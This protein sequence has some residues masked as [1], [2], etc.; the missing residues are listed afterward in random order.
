MLNFECRHLESVRAA[1][2]FRGIQNLKL[3]TQ[4]FPPFLPKKWDIPNP[5]FPLH[6]RR[7][8]NLIAMRK[9]LLPFLILCSFVSYAQRPD[10]Q[11]R[12]KAAPAVRLTQLQQL[13][14]DAQSKGLRF[15]MSFTKAFEIGIKNLAGGLEPQIS[16][17]QA[18]KISK[19][20]KMQL[21]KY[22]LSMQKAAGINP[23][24]QKILQEIQ[25]A[26]SCKA[27]AAAYDARNQNYMTVAKAQ[28]NCGSCWAFAGVSILEAGY[29]RVNKMTI[30]ASEQELLNCAYGYNRDM[31]CSQGGWI[32]KTVAWIVDHGITSETQVPYVTADQSCNNFTD[33]MYGAISWGFVSETNPGMP[34]KEEIKQAICEHGPVASR[35]WVYSEAFTA[36]DGQGNVYSETFPANVNADQKRGHFVT[37]CGWDDAKG[38]WLIKNSWGAD[39]GESGYGWISYTSN[40]IGT[41]VVWIEPKVE[42]MKTWDP[43]IINL[44][45]KPVG[46]LQTKPIDQLLKVDDINFLKLQKPPLNP[47]PS[48]IKNF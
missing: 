29:M 46:D 35:M 39:W 13:R 26:S 42:K 6:L 17:E 36:Y 9:L 31:N 5:E 4:N 15:S 44:M 1:W 27:N 20:G 11:V 24:I 34:T 38:A 21:D 16:K 33:K 7:T 32:D 41:W 37:I 45:N 47:Q 40:S 2:I 48:R 10:L 8:L 22:R 12:E 30:D 25:S 3:K 23:A 28:G 14:T 43:I 18:I 19:D